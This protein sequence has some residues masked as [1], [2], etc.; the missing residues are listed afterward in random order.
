MILLI[1][2][3]IPKGFI[4][5]DGYHTV[6]DGKLTFIGGRLINKTL[7]ALQAEQLLQMYQAGQI[8]IKGEKQ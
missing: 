6:T 5:P 3:I 1:P 4:A 7:T 2:T 8:E